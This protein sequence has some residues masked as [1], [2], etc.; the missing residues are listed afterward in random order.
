MTSHS[1]IAPAPPLL[2]RPPRGRP[3]PPWVC[4]SARAARP[5]AAWRSRASRAAT[6]LRGGSGCRDRKSTRLN[7]SHVYISYSLFFYLMMRPPPRSTLF[8]YTPLFRSLAQLGQEQHGVQEL[9]AQQLVF[10][11][12]LGADGGDFGRRQHN[13]LHGGLLEALFQ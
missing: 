7:S 6:G 8:P 9:P 5:R 1:R 4:R 3:S 12:V 2:L 10:G 11:G 13:K